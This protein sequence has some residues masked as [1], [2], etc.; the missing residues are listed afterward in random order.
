MAGCRVHPDDFEGCISTYFTSFDARID[1]RMEFRI[2]RADGEYRW[3]IDTAMPRHHEGEF[4]GFISSCMDVTEEKL[5]ERGCGTNEAQL[6]DAQ[7]LAHVGSWQIDLELSVSI[8]PMRC[9]GFSGCQ[10]LHPHVFQLSETC[11]SHG[12]AIVLEAR[13]RAISSSRR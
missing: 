1:F 2:R 7:H 8:G 10:R 9:F 11:P 12:P 13:D 3:V 4:T 6:K 5:P